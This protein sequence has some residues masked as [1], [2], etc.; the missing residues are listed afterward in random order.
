MALFDSALV[1]AANA[2]DAVIT[3]VQLHSGAPGAAGTSNV[4]STA[5]VAVN[6]SVD[7]DGD[8]TIVGSWTGLSAGQT[9]GGISYWGSAGTGT[10]PTGGTCYGAGVPTG[11]LAA[12]AAGEYTGTIV[13]T[14]TAT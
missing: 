5:R 11:D 12:N 14:S 4:V 3:H 10:P 1:V 8:L 2:I 9:V 7:A 6:G 13:E